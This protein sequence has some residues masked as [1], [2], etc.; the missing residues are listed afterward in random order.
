MGN[1]QISAEDFRK[2]MAN[3]TYKVSKKGISTKKKKKKDSN[4]KNDKIKKAKAKSKKETREENRAKRIESNYI[5]IVMRELIPGLNGDNGLIR[6]DRWKRK[7]RKDRYYN[8]IYK[9]TKNKIVG[10]CII[11]YTRYTTQLQDYDNASASVK[12]PF[13]CMVEAGIIEDDNP[14]VVKRFFPIQ[15]KVKTHAEHRV[16][17]EI[18]KIDENNFNGIITENVINKLLDIEF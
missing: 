1:D 14:K 13:D 4:Q 17:F 18:Y 15:V 8:F 3:G 9:E 2:R 12:I 6:E 7:D 11:V 10:P 16:E 5:K